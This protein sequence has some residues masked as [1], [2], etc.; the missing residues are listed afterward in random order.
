M[1][2]LG[3][4]G[5]IVTADLCLEAMLLRLVGRPAPQSVAAC[6]AQIEML[7]NNSGLYEASDY[8]GLWTPDVLKAVHAR[9]ED[10]EFCNLIHCFM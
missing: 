2:A 4:R 1:K 10:E 5:K 7:T 9:E 6:K 3:K 8:K